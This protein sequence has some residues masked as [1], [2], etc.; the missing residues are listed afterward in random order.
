MSDQLVLSPEQRDRISLCCL[1]NDVD[2][3]GVVD[4]FALLAEVAAEHFPEI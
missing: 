4:T 3:V 1:L 2:K